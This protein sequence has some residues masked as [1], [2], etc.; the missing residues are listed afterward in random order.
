MVLTYQDEGR[1]GYSLYSSEKCGEL[2]RQVQFLWEVENGTLYTRTLA[3]ETRK[4]K[5]V[6]EQIVKV[7]GKQYVLMGP[8]GIEQTRIRSNIVCDS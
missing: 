7:D 4:A 8:D 2:K 3:T 5:M 6:V 1:G